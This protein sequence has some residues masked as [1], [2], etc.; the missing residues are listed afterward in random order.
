MGGS[1]SGVF[2]ISF[3]KGGRLMRGGGDVYFFFFRDV[4]ALFVLFQLEVFSRLFLC[5]AHSHAYNDGPIFQRSF[6]WRRAV[7]AANMW[8]ILLGPKLAECSQIP[9]KRIRPAFWVFAI[10]IFFLSFRKLP[11][12][13]NWPIRQEMYDVSIV[14]CFGHCV[15][16]RHSLTG[17]E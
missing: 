3:A 16:I 7:M 11:N 1:N 4:S 9:K 6:G 17:Q 10:P 12:L 2:I 15:V 5:R 13:L 8:C 14:Y